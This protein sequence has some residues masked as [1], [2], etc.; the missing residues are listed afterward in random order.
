MRKTAVEFLLQSFGHNLSK[1]KE[2]VI[3]QEVDLVSLLDNTEVDADTFCFNIEE[4]VKP[5]NL[6]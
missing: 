3:D 5:I 2:Y 6:Q 4:Y 1:I